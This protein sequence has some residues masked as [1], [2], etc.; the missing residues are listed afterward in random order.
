[1]NELNYS[2]LR[3]AIAV[4]KFSRGNNSAVFA[5]RKFATLIELI[6]LGSLLIGGGILI[7]HAGK[8][9]KAAPAK[10]AT[11]APA[12]AAAFTAGNLV[13]YRVGDGSAA[14]TATAT[15]VFLDEYT[16]GGT[17]V[18]SI[19]MPTTVNG[20]NRRLTATGNSST[21]GLMTRSVDGN[22]LIAAGYDTTL[23][24][25]TPGSAATINRVVG[26]V[27]I[28]GTIDT[29]T[30]L[31]DPTAN[32]RGAASTNG[33]DLWISCSSNGS[34]YAPLGTVGSSTQLSTSV[35]NIR[36]TA[37]FNNQLYVSSASGAFQG[38]A[39]VGSG[40]P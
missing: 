27:D 25:T 2:H 40:T 29:T 30:A 7:V 3:K 31:N 8:V 11:A 18:Q 21:E 4:T 37:I 38:V 35:T 33:T 16:P 19:A 13:V 12:L 9:P 34:R 28:N 5:R 22:Y 26:R 17:L 10:Q 24:T 15:A 20:S 36:A 1:S 32:V 14:L 39:A 6:V 23:G